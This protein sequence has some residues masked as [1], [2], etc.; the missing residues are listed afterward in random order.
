MADGRWSL[1]GMT[2]LVTGGTKGI[3]HAVVGELAGLGATVHTCAQNE[4]GL[5]ACLIDWKSKGFQVSGSVIDVSSRAQREKLME[6]VS[7]LFHGKLNILVNNV[8]SGTVKQTLEYTAED[9]STKM[10]T[11]F[12]SGYHLSQ[13][14]H[15]L[16]KASGTGTIIFVSSITSLVYLGVGSIYSSSKGAMNQLTRYLACE[17][18][19]DNIKTNA[20]APGFIK[21]PLAEQVINDKECL[22]AINTR[23]PLGR[24]GEPREASSAVAFLCLPGSSY[25]NGEIITVDGGMTLNFSL[26]ITLK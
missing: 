23:T 8:G 21:T 7:S 18:A 1:N 25:L 22:D 20:V 5:D 17:W 9:F 24:L 12:E 3:G 13:L 26:P 16:L 15:P 6:T 19:K 11:N 14:A 10:A 2:A 4:A